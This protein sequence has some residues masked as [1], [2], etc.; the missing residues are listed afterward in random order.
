MKKRVS[1]TCALIIRGDEVLAAQRSSTMR[2]PLK[3]EFPGGKMEPVEN[4]EACI[5]REIREE[6]GIGIC[7]QEALPEVEYSYPDLDLS[8]LPFICTHEQGP[9]TLREH[10]QVRWLSPQEL[11]EPE[12]AEA[13]LPVVEQWRERVHRGDFPKQE[14]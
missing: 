3:W 9:I 1:V 10:L 11:D 6:L 2:H 12:W 13:D 7:V 8:L 5:I 4:A 14:D